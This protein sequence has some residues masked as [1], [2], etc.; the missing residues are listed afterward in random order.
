MRAREAPAAAPD[1]AAVLTKALIKAARLLDVSQVKLA[2]ILGVS[3]ST[4]SRMAADKYR[5][6]PGRG[7]EWELAALFVRMFRALDSLVG[8]DEKAKAW[9]NSDNQALGE[10]PIELI[11]RAEGLVRVIHYLDAARGRI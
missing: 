7:K 6:E 10:R 5:L 8:S 1:K 4:V 9:L 3:D 2:Q 11:T